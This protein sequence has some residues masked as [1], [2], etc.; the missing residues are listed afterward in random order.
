VV[1]AAPSAHAGK[2]DTTAAA[3]AVAARSTAV[4]IEPGEGSD[5]CVAASAVVTVCVLALDT[6]RRGAEAVDEGAGV[7]VG[8]GS[9]GGL[10]R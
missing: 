8:L 3:F 7:S 9:S 6:K 4:A 5:V 2:P 1:A 10:V